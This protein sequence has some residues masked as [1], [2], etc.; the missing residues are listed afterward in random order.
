[1]SNTQ[2]LRRRSEY[3][4]VY[5][6]GFRLRTRFM[7]CFA[8][9]NGLEGPRLGI[10][11]TAKMGNAV[12]RNR[13]KRRLRELFRAHKPLKSLDIVCIPRRELSQAAWNELENDYRAALK[14][15]DGAVKA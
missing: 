9:A 4:R 5:E 1:M 12:V 8:L 6:G 11:A 13:A 3:T 7:T 10:A 2:K 15:L 14:R